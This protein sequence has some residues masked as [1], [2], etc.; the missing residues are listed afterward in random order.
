MGAK[1]C[2]RNLELPL[3]ADSNFLR[4]GATTTT[5]LTIISST[6]ILTL[7]LNAAKMGGSSLSA[8]SKSNCKKLTFLQVNK[9][10]LVIS[11]ELYER[12]KMANHTQKRVH[13][14]FLLFFRWEKR[15][16]K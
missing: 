15:F 11:S 14:N 10:G 3:K 1:N 9:K 8:Q 4:G 7:A 5:T 6:E 2:T 13:H 12:F 16:Y